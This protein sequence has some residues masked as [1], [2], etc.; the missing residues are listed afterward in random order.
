MIKDVEHFFQVLLEIALNLY[1]AFSKMAILT[2]LI[3][4]IYEH[5]RYFHLLRSSSISFFRDLKFWSYGSFTSLVRITPKYFILVVAVVKVV[6]FLI[7]SQPI[8]KKDT[9]FFFS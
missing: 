8:D 7:F 4:P 1:I 5:G 6:V 3:L 2:I 9:V